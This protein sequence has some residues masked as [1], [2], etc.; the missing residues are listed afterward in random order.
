VGIARQAGSC[1]DGQA[2]DRQALPDVPEP[3]DRAVVLSIAHRGA[4]AYAPENTRAAFELAITMGAD[5]I[6]TD[7]QVTRDGALVLIHDDRVDRTTD[8]SG[9]VAD[10][11][12]D[13]LRQLDAGSWF[14]EEFSGERLLT[15]DEFAVEFIPRLPAC[16]EI[17]DPRA[18]VPLIAALQADT[19]RYRH[20]HVTSFSWQAAVQAAAA[21]EIPVGYLSRG[22]DD[23]VIAQCSARRIEQV[24]PPV[25]S[26]TRSLVAGAHASGLVVRAWGIKDQAD[27]DRLFETGAD[28]ATSNWPDWITNHAGYSTP[29][30]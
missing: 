23:D 5:M 9:L 6:E 2:V 7:A 1:H 3:G 16:L 12:L 13:E 27:V 25:R 15:L 24:C 29:G 8:G 26:L 20:C 11:T 19:E 10:F 4:S 28:G 22:F 21:L 18:T 30:R 17:K 14:G